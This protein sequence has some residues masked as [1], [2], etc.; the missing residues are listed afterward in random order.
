MAEDAPATDAGP[1]ALEHHN[2]PA[3]PPRAVVAVGNFDGVHLGHQTLI[4]R[5]VAIRDALVRTTPADSA[6]PNNPANPAAPEDPIAV[7]AVCFE[8]HPLSILR[9]G[10]QPPSLAGYDLRKRW[11]MEAG[12]DHVHALVPTPA[13][14]GLSPEAFIDDLIDRHRMVAMVEGH[15]FR[16][17]RARAGGLDTLR[18]IAHQRGFRL[19]LVTDPVT[20]DLNDQSMTPASSTLARWLIQHGRVSDAA[21]V[22]G[23]PYTMTGNVVHGDRLGRTIDVPTANLRTEQLLPADG[24]YAGVAVLPD[25][26]RHPAAINVGTRPTV[27]GTDRRL[28]AHLLR[29]ERTT[30]SEWAPLPGLPEYG[31]PLEL[32][33]HR[34]VR[35]QVRFAGIPALR[36]QLA[37]DIDRVRTLIGDPC[38][39]PSGVG[40]KDASE[41][42]DRVPQ[43]VPDS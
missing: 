18:T 12:A 8:P 43:T 9:P 17:G 38:T 10:R 30:S 5:A 2:H 4:Q 40:A 28:E 7:I 33:I 29:P 16:F 34:F 42:A 19:D 32:E 39:P 11:L 13:V 26:A 31:W 15:D 22:L 23:R 14:L 20:I 41:H 3:H 37:R 27:D 35:D 21:R 36:A 6:N 25:G 24:V 1:R